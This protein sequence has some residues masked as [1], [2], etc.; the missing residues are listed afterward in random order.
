MQNFPQLVP[1]F[2]VGWGFLC[3]MKDFIKNYFLSQS[4]LQYVNI[5]LLM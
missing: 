1:L 4:G 3:G 5:N 2:G